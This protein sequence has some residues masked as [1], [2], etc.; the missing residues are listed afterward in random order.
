M[1]WSAARK[2]RHREAF[3]ADLERYASEYGER[4]I[5]D[6]LERGLRFRE[7]Y[8][9]R[10]GTGTTETI[11]PVGDRYRV[12]SSCDLVFHVRVATI[13]AALEACA[14]FAKLH[15]EL[16]YAFGWPGWAGYMRMTTEDPPSDQ[17]HSP[18][19]HR[20]LRELNERRTEHAADFPRERAYG[21]TWF[22]ARVIAGP[23]EITWLSPTTERAQQF[24]GILQPLAEEIVEHFRWER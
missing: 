2:R 20:Y 11:E 1:T 24:V 13:E 10:I 3:M 5:A 12:E 7:T 14:V 18:R 9:W 21:G 15:S 19:T 23:L 4:D 8:E 16:F 17:G 6:T 22:R